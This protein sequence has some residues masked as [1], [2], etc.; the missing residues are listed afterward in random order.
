MFAIS[1]TIIYSVL[2][3]IVDLVIN[4]EGRLIPDGVDGRRVRLQSDTLSVS[5]AHR[6]HGEVCARRRTSLPVLSRLDATEIDRRPPAP[7]FPDRPVP[8]DKAPA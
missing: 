5:Q 4:A 1:P 7:R 2:E 6:L 8:S 3:Q